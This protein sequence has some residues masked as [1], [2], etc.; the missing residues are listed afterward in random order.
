[1]DK[2]LANHRYLAGDTYTIADIAVWPWY[3]ALMKNVVY[4]AAEFLQTQHYTHLMR[5]TEEVGSRQAVQRGIKVNR[6]WGDAEKQVPERHQA[7]DLD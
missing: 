7:S 5:W 6:A 1:M 3:G 2:H 4:S